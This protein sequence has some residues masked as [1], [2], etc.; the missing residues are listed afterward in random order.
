M[1]QM[2][3]MERRRNSKHDLLRSR[4]KCSLSMKQKRSREYLGLIVAIVISELAGVVGSLFTTRAIP[5]WYAGLVKPAVNPPGWVF[6]PVWTAL[7]LC[8]GVAAFLVWRKGW[9]SQQGK[10]ALAL[11]AVQ[12]VLNAGWSIIFFGLHNPQAAFMEI[13]LLWIAIVATIVAFARVH[14]P[15]AWLLAPY[16]AWVSFA[17][18]LNYALWKLN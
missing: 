4:K 1:R 3:L 11:F 9:G 14:K 18:Y 13:V 17:T 6:A 2:C 7:Y 16:L 10:V 8:M 5:T 15:A 12:W